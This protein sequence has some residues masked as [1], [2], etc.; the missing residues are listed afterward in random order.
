MIA[1]NAMTAS[2]KGI[3][4]GKQTQA[5]NSRADG[6]NRN[7][8]G[9]NGNECGGRICS[10]AGEQSAGIDRE[11]LQFAQ[12]FRHEKESTFGRFASRQ[13]EDGTQ[14]P[15]AR[16]QTADDTRRQT[17]RKGEAIGACAGIVGR[18]ASGQG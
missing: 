17:S 8:R 13:K 4:D 10:H 1:D 2:Y 7:R 18:E 11:G 12:A 5:G 9:E 3:T 6:P 14:E 15:C 16:S